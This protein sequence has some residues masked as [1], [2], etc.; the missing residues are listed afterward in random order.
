MQNVLPYNICDA[1]VAASR[2]TRN[3]SH[4]KVGH[5]R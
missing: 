4:D 2:L 1:H 5:T 3:N